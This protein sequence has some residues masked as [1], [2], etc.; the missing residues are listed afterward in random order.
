MKKLGNHFTEALKYLKESAFKFGANTEPTYVQTVG[1]EWESFGAI[2]GDEAKM[3]DIHPEAFLLAYKAPA[4]DFD[5]H[6]HTVMESGIMIQ[7]S[8]IVYTPEG[9]FKVNEG[10]SYTIPAGVWHSVKFLELENIILLQ[11]HPMFESGDWE[12]I[13]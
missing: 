12:A 7:G 13:N 11:F 4:G 8:M 5:K 9:S 3:V 6:Y 10:E 2:E 1:K